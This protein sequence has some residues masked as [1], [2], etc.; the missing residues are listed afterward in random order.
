MLPIFE[1]AAAFF[2][3]SG[4][5]AALLIKSDISSGHPQKMK[6]MSSV[7]VL[8][9]LWGSWAALYAYFRIGRIPAE[10]PRMNVQM[11]S[12]DGMSMTPAR[13][14]WQRAVLST[15]HCGAGCTLAD[16]A[17]EWL[18]YF[19]PVSAFGSYLA[20]QWIVDYILALIFGAGFQYAAIRP[21]ESL[22]V[23]QTALKAL[24]IDF[25]SLTAWQIGMYVFMAVV[26]FGFGGGAAP[27]KTGWEFW[28]MMQLAMFCGFAVSYPVNSFLVKHGIK[29]AMQV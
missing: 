26:I 15:L 5:I 25:I 29:K 13:P 27:S 18:T 8:S 23:F 22:S 24:K 17:G 12:L 16:I 19:V 10:A 21:M 7:W 9:G 20:G 28:F 2:V 4:F 1:N 11:S 3:I 6:I 14:L